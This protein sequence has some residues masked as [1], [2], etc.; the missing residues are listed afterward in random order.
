MIVAPIAAGKNNNNNYNSY[1]P[2]QQPRPVTVNQDAKVFASLLAKGEAVHYDVAPGR[3]AYLHLATAA[4]GHSGG[5]LLI[6][7]AGDGS[8]MS[9]TLA[10]GDGLFIEPQTQLRIEGHSEGLLAEFL[11]FDLAD[12]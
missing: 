9:H 5:H 4:A 8:T 2:N 1:D 11:L 10:P 12:E 7:S 3:R 6:N